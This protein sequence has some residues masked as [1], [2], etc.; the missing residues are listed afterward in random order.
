MG[1][2]RGYMKG[3]ALSAGAQSGGRLSGMY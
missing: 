2:V 1:A 3:S